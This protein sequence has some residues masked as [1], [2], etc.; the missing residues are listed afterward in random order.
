MT[1]PLCQLQPCPLTR[2]WEDEATA[3]PGKS[4]RRTG[5]KHDA[6]KPR[7]RENPT[8]RKAGG[9]EKRSAKKPW[10]CPSANPARNHIRSRVLESKQR[11]PVR[12]PRPGVVPSAAPVRGKR[13]KPHRRQPTRVSRLSRC[14][15]SLK[16]SKKSPRRPGRPAPPRANPTAADAGKGVGAAARRRSDAEV[17]VPAAATVWQP[18]RAAAT[19]G[20]TRAAPRA[21]QAAGT[22][23]RPR[24]PRP[25]ARARRPGRAQPRRRAITSEK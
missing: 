8:G 12:V 17:L 2:G 20:P 19:D 11:Q 6:E 24:R 14:E 5:R 22:A 23:P 13:A 3:P 9:W 7:P 1:P 21:P 4:F 18:Y 16:F 15:H 25:G 10:C